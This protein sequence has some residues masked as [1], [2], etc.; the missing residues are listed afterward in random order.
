MN[1]TPSRDSGGSR[2]NGIRPRRVNP[3]SRGRRQRELG[4]I[5]SSLQTIESMGTHLNSS[6][7]E[8]SYDVFKEDDDD[9]NDDDGSDG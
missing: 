2:N 6:G 7:G 1:G 8:A 9:D 3:S 4:S 5:R